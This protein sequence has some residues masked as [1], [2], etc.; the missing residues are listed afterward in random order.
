MIY[1]FKNE[2]EEAYKENFSDIIEYKKKNKI[3]F[4]L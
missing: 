4:I 1:K 3:K 2:N